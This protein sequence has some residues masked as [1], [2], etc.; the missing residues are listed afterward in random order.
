[1]GNE[2]LES[3]IALYLARRAHLYS[4]FHVVFGATPNAD[5][6]ARIFGEPSREAFA[7]VCELFEVDVYAGLSERQMGTSNRSMSECVREVLACIKKTAIGEAGDV[8]K[9]LNSS[10]TALFCVP[11]NSFVRPWESPY[12]D[13]DS[14]LFKESTLDVR[15]YYHK[16]GFSLCAECHFPDDH[17]AAMM[18]FLGRMAHK[19]FEAYADG[20]D[21]QVRESLST[22]Y[23]FVSAHILNWVEE[24]ASKVIAKDAGGYYAAFAGAMA[25]FAVLDAT[26]CETLLQS[27]S[28][29]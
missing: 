20:L 19:T 14:T 17:I 21:A 15:H 26:Q 6:V 8:A 5:V 25:S 22:Q 18:D 3:K 23:C 1:M 13:A 4:L 2:E 27:I 10:Y 11:G 7:F 24:F 28:A 9:D 12:V 16:A 29:E